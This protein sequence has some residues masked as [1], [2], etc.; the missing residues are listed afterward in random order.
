[1]SDNIVMPQMGYDMKEGTLVRWLVKEG[2]S[3]KRGDPIAE[4][5]TDKAVVEI[6]SYFTG[7]IGKI[8]INEGESAEV[9]SSIAV[10]VKDMNESVS[11]PSSGTN[12]ISEESSS[13]VN[14][15]NTAKN[16]PVDQ[17]PVDIP[18]VD[19][20][21]SE[22]I[23]ISPVAEKLAI[24]QGIDL[25]KINGTGPGGRI[26]KAD[27]EAQVSNNKPTEQPVAKTPPQTVLPGENIPLSTTRSA[28]A[29]ITAQSKNG[30][31]HFYVSM[32]IDMT[33]AL[34][35]RQQY[36]K[37]NPNSGITVN[38]LVLMAVKLA[39]ID[40]PIFNSSFR[41]DHIEVKPD[42]NLGI[43]I[44]VDDGLIVPAITQAQDLSIIEISSAARD[45][46]KRAKEG[47]LRQEEYS[48]TFSVSNLG[49]FAVDDFNAIILP[50]QVGV[51]AVSSVIKRPVVIDDKIV[52]REI[53]NVQLSSD[54]RVIDGVDAAKF[55]KQIKDYLEMPISLFVS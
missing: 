16:I 3:L 32:S 9:G 41:E 38:S 40:Y 27:I 2:S 19:Q 44:S 34:V 25:N 15:K 52:I 12:T 36:G 14:E 13:K 7:F 37:L 5:E 8:L 26:T 22:K 46:A 31:P 42:I 54:H 18:V 4:I 11:D 6:E 29:R 28:I 39:L 48:G 1:M 49:M 55:A 50:P 10:V 21:P 33:D 30:I 51:L 24:E 20:S 53:M 47:K 23:K 45:L 35:M 43:A 17:P